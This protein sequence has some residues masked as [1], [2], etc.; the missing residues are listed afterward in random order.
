MD[1][2][3]LTEPDFTQRADPLALFSE[4]LDDAIRTEPNDPNA[5]A[6]ATVDTQGM[7]NVRMVLLKGHGENGFTFFTNFESAKGTEIL[8]TGK[9]AMCFYWKSLRRQV[10]LRGPV[11]VVEAAEADHYFGTRHPQSR[12]GARVSKQ[13]RPLVSRA[14][15]EAAVEAERAR[16]GED[17]IPRPRHW[18]GF[19]LVPQSIEF[20]QEGAHR[21][22]DRVAFRREGDGW[23]GT[24]LY[25]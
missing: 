11:E 23:A 24:R 19:R 9:A 2:R 17:H 7:P 13:S 6:L 5:L 16:F 20:W 22:H 15:L 25:P 1:A 8:A 10:R 14:E 3:T 4:W 18:S 12:L 21:L